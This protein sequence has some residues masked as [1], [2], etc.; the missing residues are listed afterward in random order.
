MYFL[1]VLVHP[2]SCYRSPLNLTVT[3]CLIAPNGV[4]LC[5]ME[6]PRDQ[7]CGALWPCT[8]PTNTSP[9]HPHNLVTRT[10]TPH[11]PYQS[12]HQVLDA[13]GLFVAGGE[14][15]SGQASP[16]LRG[17][18][19]QQCGRFFR[20]LHGS[21]REALDTL[22]AKVCLSF[23]LGLRAGLCVAVCAMFIA[24]FVIVP[25]VFGWNFGV[26]S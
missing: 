7:L 10:T 25:F 5:P 6:L 8:H 1:N 22:L 23:L 12:C 21:K 15:F 2:D 20:H 26:G 17:A 18:V 16:E 14:S 13:V 24:T 4:R 19:Q 3:M 11:P 9:H